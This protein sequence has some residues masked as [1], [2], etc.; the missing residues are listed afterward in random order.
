MMENVENSLKIGVISP[1]NLPFI[2]EEM[3]LWSAMKRQY[4]NAK[5]G[6]PTDDHD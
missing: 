3:T 1:V 5:M 2:Q 6:F 4:N